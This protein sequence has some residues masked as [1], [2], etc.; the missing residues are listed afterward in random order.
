MQRYCSWSTTA[1][2]GGADV[3]STTGPTYARQRHYATVLLDG[4]GVRSGIATTALLAVILA[5][6][7]STV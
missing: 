7:V 3:R 5:V 1:L 4:A 2:L 6:V